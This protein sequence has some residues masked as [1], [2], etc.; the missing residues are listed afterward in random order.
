M[1]E[2]RKQSRTQG[3]KK[4]NFKRKDRIKFRFNKL[5][6]ILK[7]IS[8]LWYIC[9]P[10]QISYVFKV[11][12]FLFLNHGIFKKN[13]QQECNDKVVKCARR[14]DKEKRCGLGA[15][16]LGFGLM[17][18]WVV[19]FESRQLYIRRHRFSGCSQQPV[20]K[21]WIKKNFFALL[22]IEPR[23]LGHK[24]IAQSLCSL[25]HPST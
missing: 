7:F 25:R 1:A 23:L 5:P 21:L 2:I 20:L 9:R 15:F 11:K 18:S 10:T 24:S 4:K 17:H 12:K 6:L 19:S 3:L 14:G 16:I 22:G 8:L 13:E